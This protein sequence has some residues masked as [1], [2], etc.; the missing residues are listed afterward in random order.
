MT[1]LM[2]IMTRRRANIGIL[3]YD[4]A[5]QSCVYGLQEMAN[6]ANSFRQCEEE[7]VI[8]TAVW[9]VS[10][11][12]C[13]EP[14]LPSQLLRSDLDFLVLP[15]VGRGDLPSGPVEPCCSWI[16]A[17]HGE[18]V[19]LASACGGAFYLAASGV[20]RGR[21]IT[22]HWSLGEPLAK[23]CDAAAVDTTE[24]LLD[25]GD[26]ITAGGMMAWIHMGLRLIERLLGHG[27][28]LDTARF[29]VIDPA[30]RPQSRHTSFS[31]RMDH[32]DQQVLAVQQWL[33]ANAAADVSLPKIAAMAK[34]GERTFLRRFARVTGHNPTEYCQRLRVSRSQGLLESSSMSVEQV[35]HLCG[36]EDHNS[37]R[38]LFKR[39]LGV[40][41]GE[42][43]MRSAATPG[44]FTAGR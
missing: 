15:P 40:T 17:A 24:M 31:P 26:L 32:G 44:R 25:D 4:G 6:I 30:L 12:G 16:A 34:L 20:A 7:P 5:L 18:G 22:T 8:R 43:R 1:L 14:D 41:P 39:Y 35:A 11:S 37:F 33:H 21:R 28:M 23:V 38:R 10:A 19:C 29:M 27:V 42:Y 13:V 9:R 3:A 2:A 36:Y